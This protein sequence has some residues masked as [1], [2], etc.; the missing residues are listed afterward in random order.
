ML[1]DAWRLATSSWPWSLPGNSGWKEELES[2]RTRELAQACGI[3]PSALLAAIASV[4]ALSQAQ[5]DKA[6]RLLQAV[7]DTFSNRPERLV[8]LSNGLRRISEMSTL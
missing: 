8:S 1:A 5:A 4:L 2:Q 7:A 6:L 3:S